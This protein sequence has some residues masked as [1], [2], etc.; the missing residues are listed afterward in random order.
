LI[1][2]PRGC[3]NPP[4]GTTPDI[5]QRQDDGGWPVDFE[6]YS[7]AAALEWRGYATVQAVSILHRNPA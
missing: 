3:L 4:G 1:S 2:P 7:P 5:Y 6:S